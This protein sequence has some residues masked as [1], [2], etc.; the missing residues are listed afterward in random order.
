MSFNFMDAVIVH[1]D[2]RAQDN[3]ICH[4]FHFFTLLFDMK[5]MRLDTMILVF[6][7]IEFQIL[8]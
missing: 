2:F 6:F 7:N 1:S 5:W 4:Y 8:Q 3:K